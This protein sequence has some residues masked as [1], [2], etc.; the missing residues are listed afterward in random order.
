MKILIAAL[1][2]IA[3][4]GKN[5]ILSIDEWIGKRDIHIQWNT[6]QEFHKFNSIKRNKVLIYAITLM[7]L[8]N[9]C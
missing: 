6:T 8:G 5:M 1:F 7:N 4:G 2:T 3:K 9:K